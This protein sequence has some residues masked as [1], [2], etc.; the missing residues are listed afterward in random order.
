MENNLTDTL[1]QDEFCEKISYENGKMKYS[2]GEF[3]KFEKTPS[4][5]F[6]KKILITKSVFDGYKNTNPNDLAIKNNWWSI[7]KDH[8]I[9][10]VN[11]E[12][13]QSSI[14]WTI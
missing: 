11:G 4:F 1:T 5:K 10:D 9:K 6:F 7:V 12:I 14:Q 2:K 13:Y 3:I 8:E